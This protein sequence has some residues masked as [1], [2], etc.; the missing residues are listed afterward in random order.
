MFS[1]FVTGL[2]LANLEYGALATQQRRVRCGVK[3][4]CLFGVLSLPHTYFT[5]VVCQW[6]NRG[7]MQIV[8]ME[9]RMK[10]YIDKTYHMYDDAD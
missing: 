4:A 8:P 2:F 7:E 6:P 9:M 3:Y 10:N 5:C 1:G